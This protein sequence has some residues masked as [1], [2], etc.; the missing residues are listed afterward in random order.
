MSVEWGST[1]KHQHKICI[2]SFCISNVMLRFSELF[3]KVNYA[4]CGCKIEKR[5]KIP[6][7]STTSEQIVC[8]LVEC[9]LFW[10]LLINHRKHT[11]NMMLWYPWNSRSS[12][13]S[14]FLLLSSSSC[15]VTAIILLIVLSLYGRSAAQKQNKTKCFGL[16]QSGGPWHKCVDGH[17]C[18]FSNIHI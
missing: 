8:W 2:S 5:R 14:I 7:I 17:F 15:E 3:S 10:H 6:Q 11:Y 9:E 13:L 1:N 16:W 18:C 12:A 4:L